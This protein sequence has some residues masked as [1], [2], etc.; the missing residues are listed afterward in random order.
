MSKYVIF[1]FVLFVSCS[2]ENHIRI[3]Q[4][5]NLPTG[6]T[7]YTSKDG[8]FSFYKK[9]TIKNDSFHFV[10]L[11][12]KYIKGAD[13]HL[14]NKAMQLD[15][16]EKKYIPFKKHIIK[17]YPYQEKEVYLLLSIPTDFV[18][19]RRQELVPLLE[20]YVPKD[21]V[22]KVEDIKKVEIDYDKLKK[23]YPVITECFLKSYDSIE[24]KVLKPKEEVL[25]FK[26]EW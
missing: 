21:S 20:K 17:L 16:K 15:E 24:I 22:I 8:S 18:N 6:L 23:E 14:S 10:S 1:L 2:S 3:T 4:Q 9:I 7:S 12:A 13:I 26:A 5:R 25:H 19:D 11:R